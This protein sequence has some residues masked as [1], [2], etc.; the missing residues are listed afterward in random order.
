MEEEW[1][2]RRQERWQQLRQP[3]QELRQLEQ[4]DFKLFLSPISLKSSKWYKTR[5][6]LREANSIWIDIRQFYD[7][8]LIPYS[9]VVVLF[10]SYFTLKQS[11][12]MQD[13]ILKVNGIKRLL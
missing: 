2:L 13:Q 5:P 8:C 9:S 6:D 1:R 10:L 12:K 11:H 7:A 3:Q 4:Q